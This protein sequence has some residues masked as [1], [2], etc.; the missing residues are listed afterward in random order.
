[1]T[2]QTM[3]MI[4]RLIQSNRFPLNDEKR[5]QVEIGNVLTAANV[6]FEREFRLSAK[7]IPDFLV[8]GGVAVEAKIKGQRRAIFRQLER[9]TE[10]ECVQGIVLVTSVSMHLPPTINGKPACVASLSVGWL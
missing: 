1:M 8:A 9:Y 2:A 3:E 5:T 7:D 10:H 4:V 6:E